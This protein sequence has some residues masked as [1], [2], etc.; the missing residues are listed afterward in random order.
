MKVFYGITYPKVH[1]QHQEIVANSPKEIEYVFPITKTQKPPLLRLV[2]KTTGISY[3]DYNGQ[4][5]VELLHLVN[6]I[7]FRTKKP[8]ISSFGDIEALMRYNG[9]NIQNKRFQKVFRRIIKDQQFNKFVP[10]SNITAKPLIDFNLIPADR[11]ETVYPA[12]IPRKKKIHTDKETINLLFNVGSHEN[13]VWKGGREL[14]LAFNKLK[15]NYPKL[16]L[17]IVGKKPSWLQTEEGLNLVPFI[18]REKVLKNIYP[19]ADIFVFPSHLDTFGYC[20]LEAKAFGLPIVATNHYA[21]P[22]IVD[23]NKQGYLIEDIKNKWYDDNIVGRPDYRN[24]GG[25]KFKAGELERLEIDL[26]A[27][28]EL[29][30][31]NHKLRQKFGNNNYNEVIQGKFSFKYRNKQIMKIY[32]NAIN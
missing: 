5:E 14:L 30:I 2:S 11:I 6:R 17:T 22:E 32:T 13:F 10:R 1:T 26:Y 29:L 24:W 20:L 9:K 4:T 7:G 21:I 19:K 15:K 23:H 12:I 16:T 27:A 8:W 31:E 28:L 25:P 18:P 3:T